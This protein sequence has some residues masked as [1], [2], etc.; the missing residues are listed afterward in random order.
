[1]I[2]KPLDCSCSWTSLKKYYCIYSKY[3]SGFILL[4]WI[5]PKHAPTPKYQV[6]VFKYSP[7]LDR[8]GFASNPNPP[9]PFPPLNRCHWIILLS[10]KNLRILTAIRMDHEST[11]CSEVGTFEIRNLSPS[12]DKMLNIDDVDLVN[13]SLFLYSSNLMRMQ[14]KCTLNILRNWDFPSLELRR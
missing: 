1:M 2:L 12:H 10:L 4:F 9:P 8:V 3:F 6:W 13:S 5:F 7:L 11:S 14:S